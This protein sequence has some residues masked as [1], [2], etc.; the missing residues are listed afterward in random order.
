VAKNPSE[1]RFNLKGGYHPINAQKENMVKD[2]KIIFFKSFEY[3]LDLESFSNIKFII[4]KIT[5]PPK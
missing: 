3:S 1:Y 5:G 2:K 4:I